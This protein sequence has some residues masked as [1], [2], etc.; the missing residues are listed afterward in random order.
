MSFLS[1]M[2][3]ANRSLVALAT[4]AILIFGAIVIPSL[5]Q[6]L[7]PSLEYPAV[8]V[9][10]S[11]PGASPSVVEQSVTDPLEQSIQSTP[12]IQSVTSYSNSGSSV[13]VVSYNFGTDLNQACQQIMQ[14]ISHIA[15][16]S[17]VQ[18]PQ[19]QTFNVN[20]IPVI[21]LAVTANEDQAALGADLQT[22]VVP[23]LNSINGVARVSVTGITDPIVLIT[24]NPTKMQ[25]DGVSLAA[26]QQVLPGNNLTSSA[27]QMA[28]NGRTFAISVGNQFRAISDL[29][30]LTVMGTKLVSP[31]TKAQAASPGAAN[32]CKPVPVAR[33]YKLSA[34]ATVTQAVAPSTS[35]VRT[36]GKPSLGIAITKTTDGNT[37]NISNAVHNDLASLESQLGHGAKITVISDQA[38]TIK[39][40]VSGL[41]N[42]GLIG[43]CFAILVILLFLFSLRSTLV[44]AISIPLSII[45]ALIALWIGNFSLNLFTLGGLTIAVG[46]VVD[47]SIVVLENIFRHIGHGEEKRVAILTAVREVAG[48]VTASTATTVAVFLPIAF[49]GGIVGEVFGPFAITVT[50]ALLASLF[51]ALTIIPVLAYWFLKAPKA[52]AFTPALASRGKTTVLER[53]YI[54]TVSW[55]T[56]HRAISLLAAMAI[57]IG[58]ASLLPHLGTNF[59][60]SA[61]QNTYLITQTLPV[62][63]SLDVTNKAAQQVECILSSTPQIQNYQAIIGSS[64]TF[65][66]PAGAPG[67]SNSALFSIT[68]DPNAD[69]AAFQAT[70]QD[71]LNALTSA[72]KLQLL[73]SSSGFDSSNVS[74]NVQAL[75]QATLTSA[76]QQVLDAFSKVP[77]IT[78]ITSSLAAASPFI[79][80]QVDPNKAATY[81][82]TA[83]QVGTDLRDVYSGQM[84]MTVNFNGRQE[85]V[86]LQLGTPNGKPATTVAE[87]ND[88]LL[89]ATSGQQTA[90]VKLRN[91][92]TITQTL[93][94]TQITHIGGQRT[95]TV[96]ATATTSNVGGVIRN[97]QRQINALHLPA[98]VTVAQSGVSQSQS[99][100]FQ[101]LG[102]ALLAAI[103][104]VYLVMVGTFHSL[105]QP[106]ILLISIPFAATGS[107]LLMLLTRTQ[108]GLPSLIGLLM[109]IGIV[110]TNAIVLL[111]LV[112]Q[113]RRRGMDAR[114]AVIEGGRRRLRPILMTATA[115]IL[116]LIPMALGLSKDSGFISGPLAITVIGG[117]TTSTVLT[118]LLVPTLYV[119]V[120]SHRGR[121]KRA[122]PR[123]PQPSQQP[124]VL[125]EEQVTSSVARPSLQG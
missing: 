104:L 14:Q 106:L 26:L 62:G 105:V 45:I 60:N 37:V 71:R 28:S 17:G 63:T 117:L 42:E 110:V 40:A 88:L 102:L 101:S 7:F 24:L 97:I 122:S 33:P 2:S 78:N 100:A 119:M 74:V 103:L 16:P 67:D 75:D 25:A 68:T 8:T 59:F 11:Y 41:V 5:K 66:S 85:S 43:A 54:P 111:D 95:A 4:I 79:N 108:L 64:G 98:G 125:V 114:T 121:K 47:D 32:A 107:L 112:N 10:T 38:P 123:P 49:T 53:A 29:Q 81:G 36:N 113:Y 18:T 90:F 21:Q 61:R 70:L 3:L 1:K 65:A 116:A 34:I 99:Q 48:A 44:T 94:P 93:G 23:V 27:G 9:I 50:V 22:K 89:P 82:L 52:R 115:T 84:I 80:V 19:I 69:Q 15:L 124:Q 13:I 6:D 91:I 77:N 87:M 72:G 55:V 73:S 83:Q 20:D 76:T 56:R 31:C 118:L 57:F 120:E 51:V 35:L 58:T 96:S 109:L 12:N 39:S 46:R 30:H 86:Y 92:A